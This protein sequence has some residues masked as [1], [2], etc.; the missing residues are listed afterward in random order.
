M[1]GY[2]ESA[3]VYMFDLQD[4]MM[5]LQDH[6]MGYFSDSGASVDVAQNKLCCLSA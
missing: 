2:K 6:M 3:C 4:H 5:G 1:W